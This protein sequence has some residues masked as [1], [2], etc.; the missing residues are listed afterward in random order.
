MQ[1]GLD[2][3]GWLIAGKAFSL[4]HIS[5]AS[6]SEELPSVKSVWRSEPCFIM[7]DVCSSFISLMSYGLQKW[8]NMLVIA[9]FLLSLTEDQ[10]SK[11]HWPEISWYIHSFY[12]LIHLCFASSLFVWLKSWKRWKD[13]GICFPSQT[14]KLCKA[15]PTVTALHSKPYKKTSR[16]DDKSTAGF[17]T[18]DC[19]ISMVN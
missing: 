4:S 19:Q 17:E 9:E 8:H 18:C 10:Y 5:T 3:F 12:L 16:V 1:L 6:V 13:F 2:S 15:F 11:H 14:N 7:P